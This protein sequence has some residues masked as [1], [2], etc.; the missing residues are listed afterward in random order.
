MTAQLQLTVNSEFSLLDHEMTYEST[1]YNEHINKLGVCQV[2]LK[3]DSI[4]SLSLSLSG[5][6]HTKC[7]RPEVL[8]N[9]LMPW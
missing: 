7:F 5:F 4:K 6:Q 8:T 9:H 2:M 3:P 1:R